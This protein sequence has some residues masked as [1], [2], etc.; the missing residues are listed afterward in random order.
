MLR[1]TTGFFVYLFDRYLPDPLVIV[2][3][4]TLLVF[5]AG[6]FG[7]GQSPLDMLT[8]W[9]E[10]FWS[11]LSFGM[12]MALIL[13]LG[14]TVASTPLFA[15]LVKAMASYADS[16]GKAILLVSVVSLATSWLN[17]GVGL[18][19]GA[20]LG[21]ELARRVEGVDYRLLIASAYSGFLLWHG[22][23][24]GSIP[25]LIANPGHFL[26]DQ[27]G[28]IGT[29]RTI[30]SPLNLGI[31]IVLLIAVP[32]TNWWM[33]RGIAN[34]VTIR[35]DLIADEP[36]EKAALAPRRPA[37]RLESSRAIAWIVA[38]MGGVAVVLYWSRSLGSLNLD[39][40]NF[41]LIFLGIGLHGTLRRF[42][43]TF[44]EGTRGAAAVLIQFPF[45]AGI[46]GMMSGSGLTVT[47]SNVFV[48]IAS[49]DTLPV[50]SFLAAGLVNVFIPS[51][52]GQWAVQGPIMM[53]AAQALQ[54]DQARVALAVAWGDAWT[55]MIQPFWALPALAIAGLKASDIMGFCVMVLFVSGA[56][57]GLGF[58]LF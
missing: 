40:V 39:L 44:G 38:A 42:L 54:A 14:F 24:S 31:V 18:V 4:I 52:G 5:A 35:S 22:G 25:L 9:Q 56:V 17:W 8:Y 57:I 19:I 6:I 50:L 27:I 10:G 20:I 7:Q 49:A 43:D 26:E 55:N 51:G 11:L 45:Y 33:M 46:M 13:A 23:F 28:L 16:P 32:I 21:R 48:D 3:F 37:E 58:W 53:E 1:R 12:Q 30:F 36:Q 34:P 41:I 2:V 15:R 47:V 29:D